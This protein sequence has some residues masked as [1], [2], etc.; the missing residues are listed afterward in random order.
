MV[1]A[2]PFPHMIQGSLRTLVHMQLDGSQPEQHTDW[3]QVRFHLVKLTPVH[4]QQQLFVVAG[5]FNLICCL[6]QMLTSCHLQWPKPLPKNEVISMTA[7][8]LYQLKAA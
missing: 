6:H 3:T 1:A 5:E 4:V 2:H 8:P 7:L